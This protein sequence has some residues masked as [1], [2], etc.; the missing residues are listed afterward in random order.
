MA[1]MRRFDGG[2]GTDTA[3]KDA[4]DATYSVERFI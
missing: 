3:Q 1:H 2:T 4:I